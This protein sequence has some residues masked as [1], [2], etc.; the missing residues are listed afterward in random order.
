MAKDKDIEIGEAY[1]QPQDLD[2]RDHE[3]VHDREMQMEEEDIARIEKV[4][5]WVN[6]KIFHHRSLTGLF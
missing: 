5:R 6:Q 4:Y 1:A 3:A 2:G